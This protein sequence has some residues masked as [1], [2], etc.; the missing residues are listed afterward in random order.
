MAA[1]LGVDPTPEAIGAHYAGLLDGLVYDQADPDAGLA[2]RETGLR[3]LRSRTLMR[4][5]RDR[6]RLA[7]EVLA[8][9]AAI[10]QV[11]VS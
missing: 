7:E 4:S 2:L 11:E 10:A 9:G 1:E 8:F 5:D 3:S 6:R